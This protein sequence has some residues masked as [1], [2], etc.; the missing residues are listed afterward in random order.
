MNAAAHRQENRLK[1]IDLHLL[2]ILIPRFKAFQSFSLCCYQ[3][4]VALNILIVFNQTAGPADFNV[5]SRSGLAQSKMQA[6]VTVG[7]IASAALD[8]AHLHAPARCY[9]YARSDSASVA[10]RAN[11]SKNEPVVPAGSVI[12]QEV[13]SLTGV[14][15]KNINITVVVIISKSRAAAYLF[16]QLSVAR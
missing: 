12:P 13:G 8:L 11:G 1:I 14:G 6:H 3:E 16:Q 5:L 9:L 15:D 4:P 10:P 2:S 7:R